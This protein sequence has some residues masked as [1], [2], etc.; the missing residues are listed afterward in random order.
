MKRIPRNPIRFDLFGAFASHGQEE[1]L[2]LSDPKAAQGF[3]ARVRA[4]INES[5]QNNQFLHGMWTQSMFE[6]M[7]AS[8]GNFQI[9]K[10]EDAGEVYVA[11][12]SLKV[13][14]FRLILKDGQQLLIEVKNYFQGK[15]PKKPFDISAEYLEGL[16]RYANLMNCS[17]KI[18]VYWVV[19]NLW[20]LID[21]ARFQKKGGR[22]VLT[23]QDAMT[24]NEMAKL[25]D[26]S[27]GTKFPLAI[28]VIADKTKPRS[29]DAQGNVKFT[30]ASVQMLCEHRQITEKQER[31][32]ALYL[33]FYGNWRE[34][35]PRLEIADNQPVAVEHRLVPEQDNKQGFEIIGSLSD[36]FSSFFRQATVEGARIGHLQIDL[37]PGSL[38]QLIPDDY[39]GKV[40]PLWRF[41]LEPSDPKS[42]NSS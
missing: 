8:L 17:L 27:I 22:M 11:D 30:I 20:T 23:M 33:M 40:L 36:L 10:H 29:V 37:T 1:K 19:W 28:K 32:I 24:G 13:P 5:L 12:E 4:S 41:H 18:S 34:E 16:A 25:G 14:D 6:A 26:M 35:A 2:S 9:L 3:V 7:V 21:P 38:G 42:T 31:A 39:K 15:Q